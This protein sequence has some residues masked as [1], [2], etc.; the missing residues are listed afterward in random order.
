MKFTSADR[1][2]EDSLE[3]VVAVLWARV[4]GQVHGLPTLVRHGT[5]H[6]APGCEHGTYNVSITVA[7]MVCAFHF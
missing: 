3:R 2:S 7:I 4:R 6:R 1:E 5:T